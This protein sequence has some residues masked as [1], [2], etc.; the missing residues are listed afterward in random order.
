LFSKKKAYS[1]FVH[2]LFLRVIRLVTKVFAANKLL[3]ISDIIE[4]AVAK[5]IQRFEFT[6]DAY[7]E[8]FGRPITLAEN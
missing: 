7:I 3:L 8:R 1:G 2:L 5:L 4:R 6:H